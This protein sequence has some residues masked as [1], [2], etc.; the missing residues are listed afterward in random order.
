LYSLANGSSSV[1]G[2]DGSTTTGNAGTR[3]ASGLT[4]GAAGTS[5]KAPMNSQ[6]LIIYDSNESANRTAIEANINAY[7]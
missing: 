5:F 2:L 1:V 6:E 3:G 7:Y 4:I